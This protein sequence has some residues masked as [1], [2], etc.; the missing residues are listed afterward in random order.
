MTGFRKDPRRAVAEF[1]SCL[2]LSPANCLV[3][4]NAKPEWNVSL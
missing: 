2:A 3:P 1:I 4:D